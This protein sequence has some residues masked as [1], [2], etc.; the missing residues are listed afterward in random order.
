LSLLH[1]INDALMALF[2]LLVGLEIKRE[3]IGG[4]LSSWP[5]RTL[6][7]IAAALLWD[8]SRDPNHGSADEINTTRKFRAWWDANAATMAPATPAARLADPTAWQGLTLRIARAFS[9]PVPDA[10]LTA[11]EARLVANVVAR[12]ENVERQRMQQW[13]AE[14]MT[15]LFTSPAMTS[16]R[17]VDPPIEF[18]GG[19]KAE[20]IRN[21]LYS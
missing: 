5:Q 12:W 16:L 2:F 1:W 21:R 20:Q 15:D 4:E 10:A 11:E 17:D 3:L 9:C 8:E 19:P 18:S 6:P 13:Q 7:G 14:W